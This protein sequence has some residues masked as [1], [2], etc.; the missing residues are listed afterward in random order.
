MDRQISQISTLKGRDLLA[1]HDKTDEAQQ[2]RIL[3][4]ERAISLR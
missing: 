4:H 3:L 1:I 2:V